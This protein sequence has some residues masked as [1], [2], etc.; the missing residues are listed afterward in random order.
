MAAESM[1]QDRR[2]EARPHLDGGGPDG[3][4]VLVVDDEADLVETCCRLLTARG[5]TCVRAYTAKDAITR[6]DEEHPDL[7]LTDFQLPDLDGLVVIAHARRSAPAIAG[8]LMTAY[9]APSRV[10]KAYE[11]GAVTYLA[12]PFSAAQLIAAVKTALP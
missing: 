8:I 2:S 6:I 5:Y 4:R 11:A 10:H 1:R 9:T 12:K 7:V 3:R